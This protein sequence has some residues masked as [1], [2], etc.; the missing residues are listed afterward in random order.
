MMSRQDWQEPSRPRR[1]SRCA[2]SFSASSFSRSCP[3]L[4]SDC[5]DGLP[6][7]T[8]HRGTRL[9]V[10]PSAEEPMAGGQTEHSREAS[11]TNGLSIEWRPGGAIMEN[12]PGCDS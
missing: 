4:T 5:I 12:N 1:Q 8:A 3:F 10:R 6:C 11:G 9:Q 2:P 7:P